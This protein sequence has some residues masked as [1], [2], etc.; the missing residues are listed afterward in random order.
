MCVIQYYHL[1]MITAFVN[2][3]RTVCY[4]LQGGH[5]LS[6]EPSVAEAVAAKVSR[7]SGAHDQV[8]LIC[9][10]FRCYPRFLLY[11]LLSLTESSANCS[12]QDSAASVHN[13]CHSQPLQL[14]YPASDTNELVP[15]ALCSLCSP[16]L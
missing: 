9:C 13:L 15:C 7:I 14:K 12:T 11:N 1:Y 10:L 16:P 8:F 5:L 3:G 2:I 6:P 4:I